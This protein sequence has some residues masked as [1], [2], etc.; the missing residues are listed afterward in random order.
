MSRLILLVWIL[1]SCE[2]REQAKN[3]I[4]FLSPVGFE[5]APSAHKAG[6]IERSAMLTGDELCL[7]VLYDHSISIKIIT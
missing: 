3:Q 2:K 5:L 6:V 1:L 7:K 4:K